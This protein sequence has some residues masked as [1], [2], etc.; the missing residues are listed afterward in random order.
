MSGHSESI[1][2]TILFFAT[3]DGSSHPLGNSGPS[4]VRVVELPAAALGTTNEARVTTR[5]AATTAAA[6]GAGRLLGN[7]SAL[8]LSVEGPQL[9][10]E[11]SISRDSVVPPQLRVMQKG[12]QP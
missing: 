7:I 3:S 9:P 2:A 1:R 12:E 10:P 6:T 5:K 8:F 4:A 11:A